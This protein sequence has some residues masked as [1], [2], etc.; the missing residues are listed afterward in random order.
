MARGAP[1]IIG[2]GVTVW[3][4]S[5]IGFTAPFMA[6]CSSRLAEQLGG[7]PL[8]LLGRDVFF[9]GGDH[10][11]VAERIFELAVAVAVELILDRPHER[12]APG[13]RTASDRVDVLDVD[14]DGHR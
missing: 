1:L 12:G 7:A 11:D 10:P 6:P 4:P 14:V 5:G 9:V 2:W 3:W 8:H 13:D